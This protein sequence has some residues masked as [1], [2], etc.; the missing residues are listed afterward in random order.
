MTDRPRRAP[1]YTRA[2]LVTT[3]GILFM[4]FF[5]LAATWGFASVVL[6]ALLLDLGL[7]AAGR[8]RAEAVTRRRG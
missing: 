5:T 4:A 3:G 7:Q 8:R 2:F 1:N 6:T